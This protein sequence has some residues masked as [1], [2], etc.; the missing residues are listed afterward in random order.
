MSPLTQEEVKGMLTLLLAWAPSSII[1]IIQHHY[2]SLFLP[3]TS[4]F[5][6]AVLS[7]FHQ[8]VYFLDMQI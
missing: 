3:L 7:T 8:F 1:T 5:P 6:F 4:L 2:F